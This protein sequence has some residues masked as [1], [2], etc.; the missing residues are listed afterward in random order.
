[1]MPYLN[2]HDGYSFDR[3]LGAAS[4]PYNFENLVMHFTQV[5]LKPFDN[6]KI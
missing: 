1:M 2:D 6:K 3:L 5:I 4:N